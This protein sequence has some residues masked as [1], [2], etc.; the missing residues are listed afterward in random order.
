MQ[1][2]KESGCDWRKQIERHKRTPAKLKREDWEKLAD[3]RWE[4][5]KQVIEEGS[6]KDDEGPIVLNNPRFAPK[7]YRDAITTLTLKKLGKSNVQKAKEKL[8]H[9]GKFI[10]GPPVGRQY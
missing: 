6:T 2:W 7:E 4:Q 5:D 8:E 10:P 3:K 9:L 1:F